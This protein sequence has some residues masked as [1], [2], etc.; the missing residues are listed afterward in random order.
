MWN[1]VE[2]LL[3]KSGAPPR[4][5]SHFATLNAGYR[6]SRRGWKKPSFEP[7]LL[8]HATSSAHRHVGVGEDA[9][10]DPTRAHQQHAI[11]GHR[12]AI[13]LGLRHTGGELI[14][15]RAQLDPRRQLGPDVCVEGRTGRL[16]FERLVD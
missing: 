9:R 1:R 4:N 13:V 3:A 15:H 11:R 7:G 14:G 10:Y 16:A 12:V 5:S 2:R 8:R 6:G